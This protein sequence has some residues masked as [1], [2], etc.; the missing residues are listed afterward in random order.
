MND[1]LPW[2]V[3]G[4]TFVDGSRYSD[5]VKIYQSPQWHWQYDTHELCFAI[6]QYDGQYWK[7]YHARFVDRG[8]DS[9][10]YDYGGQACRMVLVE[11]SVRGRSPH[12]AQLKE[13]GERE[14][15]R[16]YE[17]DPGMHS[18]VTASERNEKYG[19]PYT[20]GKVG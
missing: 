14:W 4:S 2:A 17:Y 10:R 6:Y 13:R 3:K 19:E 9:Y 15:I 12:S 7:L 11:Y 8:G 20:A 18:V 16:T 5:W 1:T